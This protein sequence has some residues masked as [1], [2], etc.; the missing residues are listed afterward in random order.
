MALYHIEDG[1]N[2]CYTNDI[3]AMK[4]LHKVPWANNINVIILNECTGE[5]E[6]ESRWREE[7][8]EILRHFTYEEELRNAKLDVIYSFNGEDSPHLFVDVDSLFIYLN[9]LYGD[10]CNDGETSEENFDDYMM[11][12]FKYSCCF[13]CAVKRVEDI[14]R[15]IRKVRITTEENKWNPSVKWEILLEEKT[16]RSEFEWFHKPDVK[17]CL[18]DDC[19]FPKRYDVV[20]YHGGCPD[21]LAGAYP[22]YLENKSIEFYGLQHGQELPDVSGKKIVVVDICFSRDEMIKMNKEAGYL[23]VLDHHR[24]SERTMEGLDF[25]TFDMKRS[26]AQMA[27]DHIYP[28]KARPWFINTIADRDLWVFELSDTKALCEVFNSAGYTSGPDVITM[29]ENMSVLETIKE[30]KE[31]Y[32]NLVSIGETILEF[33]QYEMEMICRRAFFT[34]LVVE[35]KTYVVN[36]VNCP[37]QYCSDVGN[38]LACDPKCDF[39]ATYNHSFRS[40]K[41]YISCRASKE[42]SIDLS[43]I[44]ATFGGGGHPKASGFTIPDTESVQDYFK[45]K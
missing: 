9:H 41:W 20:I 3:I 42:S 37:G 36:F 38:M 13:D 1:S 33:K 18:K 4:E 6:K 5:F 15:A 31:D 45:V 40:R 8:G 29:W 27:W 26:G 35:E 32:N 24:S 17:R 39:A 44:T 11:R 2:S 25:C 23:V 30:Y 43:I 16:P 34:E 10:G 14:A 28:N 22:F 7:S 19:H 21:G 12:I